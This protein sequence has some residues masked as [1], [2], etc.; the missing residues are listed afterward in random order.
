MIASS[1]FL[2]C[3]LLVC[4]PANRS[5]MSKLVKVEAQKGP[6][7]DRAVDNEGLWSHAWIRGLCLSV[8]GRRKS[9]WLFAAKQANEFG[10]KAPIC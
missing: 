8:D 7:A 1:A 9:S 6:S 4:S 2:T 5:R 10:A 3:D